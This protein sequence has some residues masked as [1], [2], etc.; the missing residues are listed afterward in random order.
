[1]NKTIII[2][3][4]VKEKNIRFTIIFCLFSLSENLNLFISPV[5]SSTIFYTCNFYKKVYGKRERG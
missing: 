3:R 5:S 2:Y 4:Q 1:M